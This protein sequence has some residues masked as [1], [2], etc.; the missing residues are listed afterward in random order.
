MSYSMTRKRKPHNEELYKKRKIFLSVVIIVAVVLVIFLGY[1]V[2]QL[3]YN[4]VYNGVYINSVDVS[5]LTREELSGKIPELFDK[6]LSKE[7]TLKIDSA[8]YTFDSLLLSPAID[9]NEMTNMAFDCGRDVGLIKRFGA[10]RNLKKNPVDIPFLLTFNNNELQKIIDTAIA[11]LDVTAVPNKIDYGKDSLII[12]RGT[13]GNGVLFDEV[14]ASIESCILNNDNIAEV[15]FKHIEPEEITYDYILRYTSDTPISADYTIENHRIRYKESQPGVSFSKDDLDTAIKNASGDTIN[16]PA[17]ITQPELTLDELNE[18][19]LAHELGKFSTDY[20]SSSND[21]AYNIKLACEKIN[22]YILAPNE[23]FSY[24]DVVGPR[25]VERGFRIANVYVGNTVQPGIGGGICQVSSTMY[26][27]VVFADLEITARRNHTLPVS[28]VP[29]GRD[30]TVSYGSTDFK[31][32]NNTN[33]PLEIRAI[34]QNGI[35]TITIVG[36]DEHPERTIKIE[37]V[38]TGT[39]SPKVIIE[40]DAQLPEGEI[41]IE[42]EGTNGS[43]YVTYKVVYENGTEISRNTLAKSTYKGK[44]RIEIHGTKKVE[45][46]VVPEPEIPEV[47]DVEVPT[48]N[49]GEVDIGEAPAE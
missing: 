45:V 8:E 40:K 33:M 42:A 13:A 30:A 47:P 37:S 19:L 48:E 14:K 4:K 5:G 32:K 2:K 7:I 16:V 29:M 36:T 34:A 28:Y 24:N 46:P 6:R 41:K 10:I 21:R 38:K 49:N 44:D 39:S 25:T 20:S 1:G 12:T 11:P 15:D 26:N 9:V 3:T 43:S 23:E 27:A 35:N 22:G 31:F 18:T 17:K